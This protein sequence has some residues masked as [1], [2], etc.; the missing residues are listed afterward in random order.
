MTSRRQR[1][2]IATTD[3]ARGSTLFVSGPARSGK[4]S[5]LWHVYTSRAP[6][7]VTLEVVDETLRLF[8][9]GAI[10]VYGL[11]D[12]FDALR[13]VA[14]QSRWHVV[15]SL[16]PEEVDRLVWLLAPELTQSRGA[17]GY[18]RA[19]GGVVLACGELAAIAP[20]P[21]PKSSALKH[22]YLR[23]AHHWLSIYGAAQ[24][25]P[26]CAP[27]TRTS[28]ERA[29][30]LRASDDLALNAVAEATTREIAETVAQLPQ[31]HSVTCIKHE[32][33]AYVADGAYRVYDV[34]DYR[35]HSLVAATK[36]AGALAGVASSDAG[37]R[38]AAAAG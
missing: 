25:A 17:P 35:G 7:V 33:K 31:F 9:P 11:A 37:G 20:N 1:R 28:V 34:L 36:T 15:T 24:H 30:F 21:L 27:C 8:D 3:A 32:G 13:S 16:D 5:L 22:A 12:T 29:V 4:S 2:A 38:P 18:A 26:D 19:V 23:F 10:R 6:R 14:G